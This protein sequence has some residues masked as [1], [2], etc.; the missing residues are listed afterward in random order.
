MP[1]G[2][3]YLLSVLPF[4]VNGLLLGFSTYFMCASFAIYYTPSPLPLA[5]PLS[6][7]FLHLYIHNN[8][9][10]HWVCRI[11]SHTCL[12]SPVPLCLHLRTRDYWIQC[13]SVLPHNKAQTWTPLYSTFCT[14]TIHY[15]L[16]NIQLLV[17]IKPAGIHG[18]VCQ[19]IACSGSPH[20]TH[21]QQRPT[22]QWVNFRLGINIRIFVPITSPTHTPPPDQN[23]TISPKVKL[24]VAR[25]ARDVCKSLNLPEIYLCKRFKST[26]FIAE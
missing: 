10:M 17:G 12:I 8:L 22:I 25:R 9:C 18:S 1:H 2:T 4:S 3:G 21:Q 23:Q 14:T 6:L 7:P 11:H 26:Q 15:G 24:P 19:W 16:E 5:L 13:A 20:S